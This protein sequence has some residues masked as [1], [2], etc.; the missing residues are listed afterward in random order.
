[1]DQASIEAEARGRL[2]DDAGGSTGTGDE[3]AAA[4]T[5][6]TAVLQDAE[7]CTSRELA[8]MYAVSEINLESSVPE[9]MPVNPEQRLAAEAASKDVAIY[10]PYAMVSQCLGYYPNHVD[11][12]ASSASELILNLSSTLLPPTTVT[13]T[14]VMNMLTVHSHNADVRK[15]RAAYEWLRGL[16]VPTAQFEPN[17]GHVVSFVGLVAQVAHEVNELLDGTRVGDDAWRFFD[18]GVSSDGDV[19]RSRTYGGQTM[20]IR[21]EAAACQRYWLTL[22]VLNGLL[23]ELRLEMR[24]SRSYVRLTNQMTSLLRIGDQRVSL[25]AAGKAAAEIAF[26]AGDCNELGIVVNMGNVHWVSAVEDISKRKI[27]M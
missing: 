27:V 26:E 20:T 4:G 16:A 25:A 7:Q 6:L 10:L 15:V 19:A 12:I 14:S 5:P 11:S 3:T 23:V 18:S 8:E 17:V 21:G 1:M 24:L 13:R 9:N 2:V 22:D